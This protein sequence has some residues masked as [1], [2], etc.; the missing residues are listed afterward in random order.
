MTQN[1]IVLSLANVTLSLPGADG[2]VHI[3]KGIDGEI[4]AGEIVAITGRSGS[5]KSS[6]LAVSTGLE[7]ASGGSVKLLGTE[8]VGLNEDQLAAVRRGR[9]GIVFQ[10]FHL[11]PNMTALEN[12]AT[13]LETA[14]IS[15][16]KAA[17]EAAAAALE[18]VGLSHRLKHYPSQLSGGEQQRVAVA[19]A[20]VIQPKLIFADEPTGNLDQAAGQSVRDLLFDAARS[21]GAALPC[22]CLR[23]DSSSRRWEG[24]FVT[25]WSYAFNIAV[26]EL[27]SGIKGFRLFLVCLAIGV[28]AIAAA[29]SMAQAFRSG[30]DAEQRRILGGDFVL[31]LRQRTPSAGQLTFFSQRGVTS[32]AIDSNTMGTSGDIRRLIQLRAVDE[33]HPLEGSVT[34]TPQQPLQD[35][36]AEKDGIW[37]AVAEQALLDAFKLRV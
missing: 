18:K 22:C 1:D 8:L 14:D 31:N 16:G 20:T 13:A 37:G 6:L 3:L 5:G 4:R 23:P 19:R 11:L 29:G 17:R 2:P 25:R 33:V 28:A 30:L 21:Q 24:R 26:A 15:T 9:I 34:L 7:P 35:L 32:L 36:L 10:A 27:R 12:V